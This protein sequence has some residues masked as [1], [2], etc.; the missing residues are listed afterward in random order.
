MH[1]SNVGFSSLLFM[2]Y[3]PLN[4]FCS[5]KCL[6][7]APSIRDS[8]PL[9]AGWRCQNMLLWEDRTCYCTKT[10]PRW[11]PICYP[12]QQQS[13][14]LQKNWVSSMKGSLSIQYALQGQPTK[15]SPHKQGAR[16]AAMEWVRQARSSST[17]IWL[18]PC[19][20]ALVSLCFPYKMHPD[21][22]RL[23]LF[24][25][26]LPH[27]VRID[28]ECFLFSTV[29]PTYTQCT[30]PWDGVHISTYPLT[31]WPQSILYSNFNCWLHRPHRNLLKW[32]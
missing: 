26:L 21:A 7:V 6:P 13:S 19:Q 9:L 20:V 22:L 32:V 14:N 2:W 1:I 10:S 5:W 17:Q 4:L 27:A 31:H 16:L 12:S 18:R 25:W 23:L 30:W 28:A 11:K 3:H 8:K 24:S 15:Q 29:S